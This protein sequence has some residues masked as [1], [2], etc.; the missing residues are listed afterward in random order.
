MLFVPAPVWS[1]SLLA[2]FGSGWAEAGAAKEMF[3]YTAVC[4][5]VYNQ[6]VLVQQQQKSFIWET[7]NLS[8]CAERS[9][10]LKK[11]INLKNVGTIFLNKKLNKIVTCHVSC[12]MC[13]LTPVTCHL[14]LFTCLAYF[15]SYIKALDA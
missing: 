2:P 4:V 5:L 7:L 10:N 12:A 1:V 6:K 14:S 8:T 11:K 3:T 9:T 13:Q 15:L